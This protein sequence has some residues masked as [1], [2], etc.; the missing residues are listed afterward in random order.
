[1]TERSR[2]AFTLVELLV[3]IAI[4]GIL[5][6]LLLPAIQAA[7]EAAR[8]SQC[9]NNL[10]QTSLAC[11]NFESA[12][13]YFPP[14]GPTCLDIQSQFPPGHSDMPAWWVSGSNGTNAMCY[15][16]NWALQLFSYIEQ[17]SLAAL[18]KQALNDPSEEERANPP[19]TWDMQG[20][21]S[22][23]WTSFHENVSSTMLC[24]SSG[25]DPKI[26]YNDD[27]DETTGMSLG[28]LSKANYAAC[29]GGNTMLNAV[30][31]ESTL[32]GSIN[33][34]PEYAGLFGM[35]RCAK[36]PI[37]ARLG[38]GTKASQV[39]D[40]LSNTVMLA[41]VLTWNEENEAGSPVENSG[42]PQG[43]DD[44]RGAWM[45]P[46][47]GASAFSGRFPPNAKGRGPDFRGTGDFD[48]GDQIPACGTDIDRS[49]EF[50]EIPCKEDKST[51]NTW[52]SA[53]SRHTGGV[54]AAMGD[55]SVRFVENEV[56]PS[57]WH[58]MCTRAGE[59]SVDTGAGL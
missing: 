39:S 12:N 18:S 29:F 58:A 53:R 45:V 44:W 6:A 7:R 2:S 57:V 52:A 26:P 25:T 43:N 54:N 17:G 49:P 24:P 5:V 21:G 55:S 1:M 13:T 31:T 3:V 11:A 15:G 38:K 4:I 10:K 20:K 33:P 9:T 48:R 37:G 51:S 47:M 8:R 56:E 32:P 59:E 19:D 50:P 41:E 40:G 30:P 46:G 36:Y 42:V 22:R 28:H 23:H 27:D 35:V 14:G 34:Q 16:P